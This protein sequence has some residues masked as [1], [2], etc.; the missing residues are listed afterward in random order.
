MK[1]I[2][3]DDSLVMRKIIVSV[4]ESLGYD[5][6]HATNGQNLLEIGICRG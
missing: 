5:G 4:V 2:V 1:V 3:V 6:V